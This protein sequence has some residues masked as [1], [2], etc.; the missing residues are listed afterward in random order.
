MSFQTGLSGL[1]TSRQNLD[2]IGNNIANANT[3]GFK[4]SRSEFS[5]LVA[6]AL[7]SAGGGGEVGLGAST[8]TV[9]QIF[10]QG[11]INITGNTLDVAVNGGGFFQVTK[12]DGSTAFT[13][14]GQF[15]VS[16]DGYILTN[17]GANVM[18]FPT[19][20]S[21]VK[22]SNSQIKLQV[23]SGAPIAAK[24]TGTITAE[25]N[26]DAR[27]PIAATASPP[28]PIGTYGTSITAFDSQGVTLPVSLYFSRLDPAVAALPLP[29][30]GSTTND[31]WAIYDTA[32]GTPSPIGYMAFDD[33]GAL[34]ATYT[35]AKVETGT[36]GQIT[37]QLTPSAPSVV[38]AFN[39]TLDV[40]KA[41]QY[42]VPFN[43]S[44][45]KQDGYTAGD[46]TGVSIETSGIITTRY[47]NG[48]TQSNGQMSLSDFR[49][50]QGLKQFGAGEYGETTTSGQPIQGTPGSGKFGGLRSGAVEESN[51]DLTAE[52]IAMMTAQRNYQANAQTIK[53]QDQVMST[54][55]NMR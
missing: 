46:L 22:T 12:Q 20:T 49:N 38:P 31:N 18:G 42:G 9:A 19:D 45:L 24:Q 5:E 37:H 1:N 51:V 30:S 29:A 33:K 7:G 43:V 55:V 26:L 23:P 41:S 10:N 39:V 54:L 8:A 34:S 36:L 35:A 6:S 25:L 28:T 17:T 47:S 2:V 3:V 50:V 40:T 15:K 14:D 32:T 48:I 27:V 53:T 44:N 11:S 21:G 52:L 13:R 16:P 4:A